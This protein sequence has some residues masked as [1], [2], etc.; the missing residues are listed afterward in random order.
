MRSLTGIHCSAAIIS[1]I[2]VGL[3]V[4]LV[5]EFYLLINITAFLSM[6]ILALSLALVWGFGGII[7]YGQA[8]FFGVGCYVYSI[9]GINFGTTTPAV[10][11][12]IGAPALFAAIIGYMVFYG[13]LSSVYVSVITLAVSLILFKLMNSTAGHGFKIGKAKLGGFNG[14]PNTPILHWPFS[15]T[16]LGPEEMFYLALACVAVLYVFCK[17]LL[18]T[19]FGRAVVAVRENEVRAEL[20]GYDTRALKL[21]IFV[22]GAAIAGVSGVMYANSVYV[23]PNVFGL[24]TMAQS[25]IWV[26][27]GGV[28]TL[29][30]PVLACVAL[31]WLAGEL[32]ANSRIDPNIVLGLILILFVRFVPKG[33]LP[34]AFV[35]F[36]RIWTTAPKPQTEKESEGRHGD[37][38]SRQTEAVI[39][40]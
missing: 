10:F 22:V 19:N 2:L 38:G 15:K 12:A 5:A 37:L 39:K 36:E 8:A 6:S 23:S 7:S 4:P 18:T 21:G 20:L 34:S 40:K 31:T 26:V 1:A 30:G 27:V 35:L 9:S 16:I 33:F 11:L 17:W 32:G 28:G 14:I 3:I 29:M 13:R 25:L 24:F